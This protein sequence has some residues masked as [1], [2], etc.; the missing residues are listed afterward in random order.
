MATFLRWMAFSSVGAMGM[1]VQLV[2][3]VT[4]AELVESHYLVATV[5]AIEAAILH[6]F[7]WHERWTWADRVDGARGRWGRLARFNLVSGSLAVTGQ[8]VFTAL[9]VGVFSIHYA[10]ANIM[11][12]ASCSLFNFVANDRLVFRRIA[13][14][15]L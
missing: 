9:Y 12:I 1:G 5:V 14:S 15:P 4:L 11:A 10:A 2:T 13:P 7:V 8:L 3:L 6:N